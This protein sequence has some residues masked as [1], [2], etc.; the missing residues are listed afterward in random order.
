MNSSSDGFQIQITRQLDVDAG[1]AYSKLVEEFSMWYDASHSYSGEA[2]NLSLDLEEKCMLE[3][4]PDGGYVRH[5]EIVFHQPGKVFRMTGG[6]GP[7]QG[8]GVTGALTYEFVEGDEGTEVKMTY[9]VS[10]ASSLQLDAIAVPVNQVLGLQMDR[11][12]NHCNN[13]EGQSP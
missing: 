7:L 2:A 5:M 3:R 4:L 9:N 10:G 1:T 12:A 8:M 13:D 11:F 6:L